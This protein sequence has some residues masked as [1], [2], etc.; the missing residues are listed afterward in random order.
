[1][2]FY[3]LGPYGDSNPIVLD[4]YISNK[5]YQIIEMTKMV[6]YTILTG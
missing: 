4:P 1:M 2:G 5:C 3:F 6:K